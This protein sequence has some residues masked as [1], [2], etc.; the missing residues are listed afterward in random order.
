M[1]FDDAFKV[2]T[3]RAVKRSG[4]LS[5]AYPK[6]GGVVDCHIYI[7]KEL[8]DSGDVAARPE[9]QDMAYVD[10]SVYRPVRGDYIVQEGVRWD[11]V[12]AL[13]QDVGSM[14]S[15]RVSRVGDA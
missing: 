3:D 9:Y 10:L 4:R 14:G 2:A 6:T 11:V 5:T 15:I 7:S 1:P 12:G 13:D 8:V